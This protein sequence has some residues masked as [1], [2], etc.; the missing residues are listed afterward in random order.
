MD[1]LLENI[2][3]VDEIKSYNL[4]LKQAVMITL[5][6]DGD[7]RTYTLRL[8]IDA[9]INHI[10]AMLKKKLTLNE[11]DQLIDIVEG[12]DSFFA[13][14]NKILDS[15][16]LPIDKSLTPDGIAKKLTCR[17][18]KGTVVKCAMSKTLTMLVERKVKHNPTGKYI[19]RSKKYLVHDD[20]EICKIGDTIIAVSSKPLSKRKHHRL[21]RRV[22]FT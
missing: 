10:S 20:N 7:T 16:V 6:R 11:Y 15:Y 2:E 17:Y 5:K 4:A 9:L 22:L 12:W 1:I 3:T 14:N 19:T 21:F 13:Y 18:L 8:K